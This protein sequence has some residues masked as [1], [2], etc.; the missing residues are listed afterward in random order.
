MPVRGVSGMHE[1]V[2]RCDG[3]GKSFDGREVLAG[4]D[5]T[6]CSGEVVGLIGSSGC[7]KTTLLRIMGGLEVPT[8]GTLRYGSRAALR[9]A[10]VF[11]E[12]RL[13]PWLS[14]LGNL[15]FVTGRRGERRAKEALDTVEL[16][17]FADHYPDQLSGGMSRRVGLARALVHDPEVVLMDE[18]FAGLD[19][20]LRMQMIDFLNGLIAGKSMSV[21][22][23]SHDTREL[24]QL[25]D[26][27]YVI[28]G[29]PATVCEEI[30]LLPRAERMKAPGYLRK[31]E[32]EML[33][34]MAR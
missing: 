25:C 10:F 5:I 8:A 16:K 26:R 27:I 34:G 29:S 21:V 24:V 23:V 17:P 22:F 30:R 11:Q 12:P 14:V 31:V 32:E 4:V 9:T 33:A 13:V 20:P 3:V 2:M 18:P 7:G 1:F 15:L 19:F 28:G 6:L